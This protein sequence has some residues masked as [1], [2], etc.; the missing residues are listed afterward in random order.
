MFYYLLNTFVVYTLVFV[1][2]NVS[3]LI[4][5]RVG[6]AIQNLLIFTAWALTMRYLVN[7][8]RVPWVM[9]LY[10]FCILAVLMSNTL[11]CLVSFHYPEQDFTI[12]I[13]TKHSYRMRIALLWFDT[14]AFFFVIYLLEHRPN[15]P[16]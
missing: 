15:H 7:P 13:D 8:E 5:P 1:V 10:S 11:F 2:M 9:V 6:D 12:I 16:I 14:L 3:L 4:T